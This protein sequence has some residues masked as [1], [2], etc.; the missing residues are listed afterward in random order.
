MVPNLNNLS[1]KNFIGLLSDNDYITP[2]KKL[3]DQE[4]TCGNL[5]GR[6]LST[7]SYDIKKFRLQSVSEP[8]NGI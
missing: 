3:T 7:W 8:F 6:F 4:K 1:L 5:K 2:L